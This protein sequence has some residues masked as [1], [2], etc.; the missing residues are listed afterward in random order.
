MKGRER[1]ANVC[2]S[3]LH[4]KS[5]NF[6]VL[7]KVSRLAFPSHEAMLRMFL[8]EGN[9]IIIFFSFSLHSLEI[10]VSRDIHT[11]SRASNLFFY[12]IPERKRI[13]N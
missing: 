8:H 7:F 3:L 5:F 6:L 1:N 9:L 11:H 10:K 13:L 4:Y 12:N 2:N